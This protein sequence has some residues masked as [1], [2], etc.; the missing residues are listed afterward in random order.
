[1]VSRRHFLSLIITA[2]LISGAVSGVVQASEDDRE[3]ACTGDP[4]NIEALEDEYD[5]DAAGIAGTI[6]SPA[7]LDIDAVYLETTATTGA[8][9]DTFYITIFHTDLGTAEN[10]IYINISS[11]GAVSELQNIDWSEKED[12][13]KL[14]LSDPSQNASFR[15]Q[16][17]SFEDDICLQISANDPQEVEF[18]WKFTISQNNV[19]KWYP[20]PE[21]AT[22]TATPTPDA[23]PT[24]TQTPSPTATQTPSPTEQTPPFSSV[25]DQ[26]TPTTS[27]SGPGFGVT[28][29]LVAVLI[30]G[31]LSWLRQ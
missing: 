26:A 19:N 17:D 10:N 6:N 29:A 18:D 30:A 22:S 13:P 16:D 12:D 2:L 9:P 11:Y 25:A 23:A 21:A 24:A 3:S 31:M 7:N 4:T 15:V 14:T 1:M 5:A 8:D 20:A 28:V 27:A